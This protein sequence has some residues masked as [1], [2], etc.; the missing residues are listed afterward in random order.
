MNKP[1]LHNVLRLILLA[2]DNDESKRES[3]FWDPATLLGWL[4]SGKL[5]QLL[6]AADCTFQKVTKRL[7]L[8]V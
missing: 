1:K 7:D 2:A 6:S 8:F 4:Y 5:C 3:A